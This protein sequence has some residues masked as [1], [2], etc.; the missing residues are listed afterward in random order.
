MGVTLQKSKNHF[1]LLNKHPQHLGVQ[2]KKVNNILDTYFITIEITNL[3]EQLNSIV[4]FSLLHRFS[5]FK[6]F[7]I[8]IVSLLHQQAFIGTASFP[9]EIYHNWQFVEENLKN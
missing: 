3:Y 2:I 5:L 7:S 4:V 6:I 1:Y 9:I 8:I